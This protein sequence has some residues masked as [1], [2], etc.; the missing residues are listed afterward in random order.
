MAEIPVESRPAGRRRVRP[1]SFGQLFQGLRRP[2][3]FFGQLVARIQDDRMPTIAAALAYYLFFSIFPFLIFLLALV[4][5]V[6]VEGLDQWVMQMLERAVPPEAATLFA[7]TVRDLLAQPRGGLVSLGAVLALWSASA[8]IVGLMDGL[9]MAYRVPESRPWWRI[10]LVALG[11][12]A[13]LS[14]F[15]I[16]AFVLAVLGGAISTAVAD[17][18]GPIG[19]VAVTIGRWLVAIAAVSLVVAILYY[20]GPDVEH[21]RFTWVTPG[22]V[23][24]TAGFALAS[25]AFSLYVTRFGSYNATYGSLGAVIILLLWMYILAVFLLL[26]GHVNALLEHMSEVGKAPGERAPG[27]EATPEGTRARGGSA[28]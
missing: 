13:G 5:L 2:R 15:V 18:L 1:P 14:V 23:L 8:A 27:R 19:M 12:T 7:S 21:A 24:F 4:T 16:L 6:P 11:L 26:G 3:E 9:D 20:A 17:V 10:R 28:G 22:S 25:A